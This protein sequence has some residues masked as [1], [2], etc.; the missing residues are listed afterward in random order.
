[1][2]LETCMS[3]RAEATSRGRDDGFTLIEM[4]VAL[5]IFSLAALAL[6]RLQGVAL[7]TTARLDEGALA[8]IAAQNLAVEAMVASQPPTLGVT[9][10]RE[11]VGGRDWQWT[12]TVRRS[13]DPRL[14]LI[15]IVVK[16]PDGRV[17]ASRTVVRRAS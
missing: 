3:K 17:A 15:E 14:Q 9:T 16:D 12:Q 5:A 7:A 1:M 13:P 10:G 2:P 11:T 6:L 8:G 4:L